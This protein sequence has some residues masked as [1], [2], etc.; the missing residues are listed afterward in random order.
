M[1]RGEV[2]AKMEIP[3][4][5]FGID[6][7]AGFEDASVG[8]NNVEAAVLGDGFVNGGFEGGVI[9]NVADGSGEAL[10][11]E[12]GGDVGVD[13]EADDGG[14]VVAKTFGGGAADS[15]AGSSDDGDFSGVNLFR[16]GIEMG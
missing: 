15:S 8:D 6:V 14:S 11:G 16:H 4:V 13:V 1:G 10:A 9:G 5:F 3:A 12:V 7:F 2:N